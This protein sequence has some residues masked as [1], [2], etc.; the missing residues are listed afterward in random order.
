MPEENVIRKV[1]KNEITWIFFIGS[2][3]VAFFTQVVIPINN[4]QIQLATIQNQIVDYGNQNRDINDRITK[5]SNDL[6]RLKEKLGI[7]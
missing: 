5:N 1:L 2:F 3:I 6:I 7:Q 4:M